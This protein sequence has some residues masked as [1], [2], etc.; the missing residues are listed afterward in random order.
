VANHEPS[1]SVRRYGTGLKEEVVRFPSSSPLSVFAS[2]S[3]LALAFATVWN[4]LKMLRSGG[5]MSFHLSSSFI[6]F[7]SVTIF[8]PLCFEYGFALSPFTFVRGAGL[9]RV[10]S[11]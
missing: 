11:I 5:E 1:F 9:L 2:S 3:F 7:S 10:F 4:A 8:G 6:I